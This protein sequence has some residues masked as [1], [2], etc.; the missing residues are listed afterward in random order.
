[1]PV[2]AMVIVEAV[3]T[4]PGAMTEAAAVM[5]EKEAEN[6]PTV[7]T[8][9]EAATIVAEAVR[10]VVAAVAGIE[11]ARRTAEVVAVIPEAVREV[12]VAIEIIAGTE[13]VVDARMAHDRL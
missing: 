4:A 11:V 8:A 2:E 10:E 1:M 13:V 6:A 12:V 3:A 5:E 9:A 7:L